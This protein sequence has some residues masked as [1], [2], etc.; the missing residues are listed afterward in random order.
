MGEYSH[1]Q[2]KP[3]LR[4]FGFFFSNAYGIKNLP[5]LSGKSK[6][7][8]MSMQNAYSYHLCYCIMMLMSNYN[9]SNNL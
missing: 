5:A 8:R 1:I 2:K 7:K 6:R 4:R 3:P 9:D